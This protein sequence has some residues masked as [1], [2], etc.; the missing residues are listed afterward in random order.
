LLPASGA[1]LPILT[2]ALLWYSDFLISW[3]GILANCLTVL[4]LIPLGK[5]FSTQNGEDRLQRR[6][7][8][9]ILVMGK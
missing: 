2:R 4:G 1:K 7:L 3:T 5:W 9:D 8:D 6:F